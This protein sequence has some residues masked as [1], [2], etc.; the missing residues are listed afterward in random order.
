MSDRREL[1][2]RFKHHPS[3]YSGISHAQDD[4]RLAFR[5]I[6]RVVD[7]LC[8]DGREKALAFTKIEEGMFWANAGIARSQKV[9][10]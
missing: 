7:E 4:L 1:D 6:A 3:T 9:G 5:T 8:P 10:D 2:D